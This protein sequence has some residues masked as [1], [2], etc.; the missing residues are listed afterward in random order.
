VSIQT[1]T[2]KFHTKLGSVVDSS[3]VAFLA[4]VQRGRGSIA[5]VAVGFMLP[6]HDSALVW[7]GPRKTALIKQLLMDTDWGKSDYLVID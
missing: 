2:W 3:F 1:F 4:A 6:N 5:I 7:R